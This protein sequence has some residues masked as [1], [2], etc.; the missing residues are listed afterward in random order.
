M[1]TK[2]KIIEVAVELF[3]NYGYHKTTMDLIAEKAG[4]AKGTLYWHFSSKNELFNGIIERNLNKYFNFLEEVRDNKELNT[5]QKIEYII[6]NQSTFFNKHQ[7]I[8]RELMSNQEGIDKECKERILTL[9]DKNINLLSA[10]F[11]QGINNKE[12][13]LVDSHIAA[14]AFMGINIMVSREEEL[15]LGNNLDRTNQILK[16]FIFNGIL[17]D[18]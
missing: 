3:A 6:D 1:K 13:S 16:N 2:D 8:I 4:V 7:S 12:F 9:K 17:N 18:K 14:L 10:I 15:F 5:H 11:Q